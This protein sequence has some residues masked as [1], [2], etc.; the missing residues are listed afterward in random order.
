MPKACRGVLAERMD[1]VL[2]LHRAH[3]AASVL[4]ADAAMD[5]GCMVDG[6]DD[7]SRG[8]IEWPRLQARRLP[9]LHAFAVD[10][11]SAS[12]PLCSLKFKP[13]DMPRLFGKPSSARDAIRPDA[14]RWTKIERRPRR[15]PQNHACQ[16]HGHDGGQNWPM[17]QRK[18]VAGRKN[19]R[20]SKNK[21]RPVQQGRP[22][23]KV[24]LDHAA[25][26]RWMA[27]AGGH[28]IWPNTQNMR[29][30]KACN[31]WPLLV[32]ASGQAACS[33]RGS[34]AR[35]RYPSC[36]PLTAVA[37]SAMGTKAMPFISMRAPVT[38]K[39]NLS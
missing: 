37:E 9:R 18:P 33:T 24:I 5:L 23:A 10:E 31:A 14:E 13:C 38:T 19:A 29:H 28:L 39:P 17:K 8:A 30:R 6:F 32:I 35:R 26:R 21:Q 36:R 1:T 2:K 15:V 3:G 34:A 4:C 7:A 11:N 12:P 25:L 27:V 20:D 22:T 16:H